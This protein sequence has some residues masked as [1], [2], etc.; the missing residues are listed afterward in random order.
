[1]LK[2][3][4]AKITYFI[5]LAEFSGSPSL[6]LIPKALAAYRKRAVTFAIAIINFIARVVSLSSGYSSGYSSGFLLWIYI[7]G[8][9]IAVHG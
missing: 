8:V 1:M 7:Y 3:C 2:L 9:I 5:T 6:T 4:C